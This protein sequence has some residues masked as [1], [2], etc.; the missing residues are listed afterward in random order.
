MAARDAPGHDSGPAAG[1]DPSETG[2]SG[3]R[4]SESGRSLSDAG[5]GGG[6]RGWP[7]EAAVVRCAWTAGRA[8]PS[9]RAE[10]VT[11]WLCGEALRVLEEGEGWLRVRGPDGYRSWVGTGGLRPVSRDEAAAWSGKA[12]LW[13]LGVRLEPGEEA[14]GTSLPAFLPWGAR[15]APAGDAGLRLPGGEVVRPV[16]G[17]AVD[18]EG[19]RSRFP[20]RGPA[21]VETAASW[22]G[23]PYLWGG[24]TREGADC[25]GFVQ[26]VCGLHG[27]DL[28]RD[29]ADQ[30]EA[31]TTLDPGVFGPGGWRPEELRTGDL[32]FFGE[33][34]GA[35]DHVAFH[36]GSGRILH[37]AASNGCV[38]FDHLE[39]DTGLARALRRKRVA[40][41]RPA[42]GY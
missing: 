3:S 22:L 12:T 27:L 31:V 15:T 33:G 13:S 26:A 38:D 35:V 37:A 34:P 11:Q 19:R 2:V 14:G 28:P 41:G 32:L 18:P 10:M 20:G 29:S 23:T 5:G 17:E 21:M 8:E 7:G 9:R 24:R 4:P 16:E 40:A 39:A 1:A 30:M 36:A 42:A 25:S 6:R